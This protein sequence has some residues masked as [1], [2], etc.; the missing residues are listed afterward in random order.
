MWWRSH[1]GPAWQL[2]TIMEGTSRFQRRRDWCV[3]WPFWLPWIIWRDWEDHHY[4]DDASLDDSGF[5]PDADLDGGEEDNAHAHCTKAV[6]PETDLGTFSSS[7]SLA[8]GLQQ[9]GDA[10]LNGLARAGAFNPEIPRNEADN[11]GQL[12]KASHDCY[13]VWNLF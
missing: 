6:D 4:A 5:W 3:A 13:H 2:Q 10:I 1:R 7:P 8:R 12:S 9:P 11:Y